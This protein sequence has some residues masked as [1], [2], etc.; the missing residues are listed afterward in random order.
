MSRLL[1][2]FCWYTCH[3]TTSHSTTNFI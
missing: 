3:S 2:L 1:D